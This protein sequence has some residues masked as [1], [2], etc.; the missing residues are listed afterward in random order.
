MAG[1][2]AHATHAQS[3]DWLFAQLPGDAAGYAPP[4]F[5]SA[6]S[7][8]AP[9]PSSP[10]PWGDSPPPPS[11]ED[12]GQLRA[13]YEWLQA[14]K[15]RLE[16]YTRNQFATIRQQHQ[17]LLAKHFRSEEALT[18][19]AQELNREMQYLGS[20][21]ETLQRRGRELAEREAT[22]AVQIEKVFRAQEDLLHI[23][24]TSEDIQRD[25]EAQEVVLEELRAETARLQSSEAAARSEFETFEAKLRERQQAW[26]R[27]QAEIAERQAQMEVR[28]EALEKTEEAAKRRLAEIE[29]L[30]ERM[31]R[32]FEEQEQHL[33]AQRRELEALRAKLRPPPRKHEN[34]RH[35]YGAD[36][37]AVNGAS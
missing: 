8:A 10:P 14:E 7:A 9:E 19:R 30:E 2:N 3:V 22:L 37:V 35:E 12:P 17:A 36:L 25:T 18:L 5:T 4:A 23:Q 29:E 16:Q 28:F 34:G 20:Q 27:K 33:A 11:F 13:A 26:E 1:S 32:E 31:Q 6:S 15:H 24:Q 21:A